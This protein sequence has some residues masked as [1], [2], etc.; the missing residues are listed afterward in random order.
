MSHAIQRILER[1]TEDEQRLARGIVA[2][3]GRALPHGSHAVRIMRLQR[4]RND[5]WSDVS[6][7][8]EAW[9]IVRDGRVAT[10]MLRR[11]TQPATAHA[12]RV[13]Q[14]HELQ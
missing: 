1:L 13:D 14:V 9:A 6:N 4:Q 11:S 12:M 2:K 5:A 10:V 3:L 7:G 8:D